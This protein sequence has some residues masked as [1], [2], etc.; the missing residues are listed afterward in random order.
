M[1]LEAEI[2]RLQALV[3]ER[4]ASIAAMQVEND[5]LRARVEAAEDAAARLQRE[6]EVLRK[7][8]VGPTSERVVDPNQLPLPIPGEREATPAPSKDEPPSDER[9]G[10]RGRTSPGR[11][12][13]AEMDHLRTLVF[14]E[15]VE[16]RSC[17]CGCGA[18]AQTLGFEVSWRL[19]C[20]RSSRTAGSD[21]GRLHARPV[22]GTAIGVPPGGPGGRPEG[23][24]R[25]R[26]ERRRP[27]GRPPAQWPGGR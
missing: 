8:I 20:R 7:H 14:E 16:D 24:R 11:R 6:L 9:R 23:R 4:D 18:Q 27:V 1:D 25:E 12:D 19:E 17:P 15:R 2:R 13:V 5:A 22:E 26:S 3:A 10:K 21:P